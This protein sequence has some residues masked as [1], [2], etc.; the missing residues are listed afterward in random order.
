MARAIKQ[1]ITW[2]NICGIRARENR[3]CK[4]EP[5][6]IYIEKCSKARPRKSGCWTTASLAEMWTWE[7]YQW[8]I[9]RAWVS[10]TSF[11]SFSISTYQRTWARIIYF[12][13]TGEEISRATDSRNRKVVRPAWKTQGDSRKEYGQVAKIQGRIR[14]ERNSRYW[15]NIMASQETEEA[16]DKWQGTLVRSL[17]DLFLLHPQRQGMGATFPIH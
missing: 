14:V 12:V 10:L 8:A 3:Q 17:L 2:I 7:C 6:T 13:I 1:A 4:W 11:F 15:D 9:Q 16:S 5:L